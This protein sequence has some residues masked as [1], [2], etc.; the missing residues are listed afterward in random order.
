MTSADALNLCPNYHMRYITCWRPITISSR[1][2]CEVGRSTRLSTALSHSSFYPTRFMRSSLLQPPLL[3]IDANDLSMRTPAHQA[4]AS[5]V[6]LAQV[7]LIICLNYMLFLAASASFL[8]PNSHAFNRP[9]SLRSIFLT[10]GAS[11]AGA[12]DT[13]LETMTGSVSR[14]MPSSTISSTARET[15]S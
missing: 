5:Q 11:C 8:F 9:C 2:H 13:R 3:R 14:M 4:Q 1:A 10:L 6:C 15:R 7:C 12:L